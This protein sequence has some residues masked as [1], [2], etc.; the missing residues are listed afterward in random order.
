MARLA[1]D[2]ELANSPQSTIHTDPTTGIQTM[3]LGRMWTNYMKLQLR[4]IAAQ[5]THT[6][7]T[8]DKF[9]PLFRCPFALSQPHLNPQFGAD[10]TSNSRFSQVPTTN[11]PNQLVFGKIC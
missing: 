2:S 11:Q 8:P 6:T 10:S 9:P 1:V 5:L 7:Q 4:R 3:M